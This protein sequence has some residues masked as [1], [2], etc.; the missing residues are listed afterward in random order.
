VSFSYNNKYKYN[1]NIN[2]TPIPS[3]L[4]SSSSTKIKFNKKEGLMCE[5]ESVSGCR[6]KRK[7]WAIGHAQGKG[8]MYKPPSFAQ[9]SSQ[10]SP[11]CGERSG[12]RMDCRVACVKELFIPLRATSL[13]AW[14]KTV[15]SPR[16]K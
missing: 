7:E 9:R 15:N 1:L 6:V 16:D 13:C 8:R 2:N 5:G 14:R 3:G 12:E 4:H 11:T 10:R